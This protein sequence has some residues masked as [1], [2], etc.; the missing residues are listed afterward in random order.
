MTDSTARLRTPC[1]LPF[2][3]FP[4]KTELLVRE[5]FL[6]SYPPNSLRWVILVVLNFAFL[7][8]SSTTSAQRAADSAQNYPTTAGS[9]FWNA[10]DNFWFGF[11]PWIFAINGSAGMYLG[12]SMQNGGPPDEFGFQSMGINSPNGRSWGEFANSGGSANAIRPFSSA[13]VPGETFR[14]DFDNGFIDN[15][16]S[17]GVSLTDSSGT[18]LW[19]FLFTGGQNVYQVFDS[20]GFVNTTLPFTDDGLHIDFTLTTPLT[21]SATIRLA[22]GNT[23]TI[24]GTLGTVGSVERFAFSDQNAGF[25]NIHNVYANNLAIVPEPAVIALFSVGALFSA[26]RIIRRKKK[27]NDD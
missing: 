11:E 27:S 13:L 6:C 14:V 10:G 12:D 19:Q 24:T 21:Y 5:P 22:I 3:R 16:G 15:G 7:L 25:D 9:G 2:L 26:A 1:R 18:L 17:A 4:D 20:R 23:E 8:L